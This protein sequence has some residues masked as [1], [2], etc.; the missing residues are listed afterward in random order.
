MYINYIIF[1]IIF[2]QFL[3]LLTIGRLL[4]YVTNEINFL[5]GFIQHPPKQ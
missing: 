1:I 4:K 5:Q 3:D 2:D